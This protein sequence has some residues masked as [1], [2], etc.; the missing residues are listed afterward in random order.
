MI[1]AKGDMV[2]DALVVFDPGMSGKAKEAATAIANDLAG[3][4]YQ[5]NLVGIKSRAAINYSQAPNS[6]GYAIIVVGPCYMGEA[7]ASVQ[8]YLKTFN[9]PES[10]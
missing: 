1:A 2:G 8:N 5:V 3:E 7:A 9:P 10:L 6:S 4:G